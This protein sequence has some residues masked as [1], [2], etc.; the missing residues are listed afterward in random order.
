M[1]GGRFDHH[2]N[3]QRAGSY[4]GWRGV[5]W[6][7][8][9]G[10]RVLCL[11][12]GAEAPSLGSAFE[13]DMAH[14]AALIESEWTA[15]KRQGVPGRTRLRDPEPIAAC[16]RKL[17]ARLP[18]Q[19]DRQALSLR[20]NALETGYDAAALAQL[21]EIDEEIAFVAGQ[22]ATWYGK[23]TGGL[24]TA[25]GCR[26]DEAARAAVAKARDMQGEVGDC[27]RGLRAGLTLGEVPAFAPSRVFLMAGE[28]N[29]LPKHIAYFL[30]EDEG[31]KRSPF[32]KSY[33]FTNTHRALIDA[34]SLPLARRLL[35]LGSPFP[36]EASGF[37]QIPTLGVLAHEFGHFV[38]RPETE[39]AALNAADRWN[40]VVLQEVAA[41]VFGVLILA[42]VLAPALDLPP[43]QVLGYHLAETLRYVDRGLGLF[44]DS[45]GMYLQLG[46]LTAF[47]VLAFAEAGPDGRSAPCLVGDPQAVLAG[48]RSLARVLA[49]TLLAGEVDR[50]LALCR[51]FGPGAGTETARRLAPLLEHLAEGLPT[52]IDYRQEQAVAETGARVA[53]AS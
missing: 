2:G 14:L 43:E 8:A 33:Y 28:G 52:S 1:T 53:I 10:Y 24:P 47:G 46:Y 44:P 42:E 35:D 22:I 5:F 18:A 27:L 19:N 31:V 36:E 39:F 15:C 32:K 51:D 7:P 50:S 21:A 11:D 9:D 4:R 38:H 16:L 26:R 40:S 23:Q 3:R 17:A 30:P 48:F 37:G 25:F 41:D 34:V 12:I 13:E 45:D 20:A 6:P 29:R 49:D